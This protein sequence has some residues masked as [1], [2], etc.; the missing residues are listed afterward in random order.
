MYTLFALL[1]LSAALPQY[2]LAGRPRP[3]G[4]ATPGAFEPL[5]LL[6]PPAPIEVSL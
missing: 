5:P 3:P 6:P 4:A 2:D 1:V